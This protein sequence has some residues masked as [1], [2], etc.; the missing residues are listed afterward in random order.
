MKIECWNIRGFNKPLK[1]KCV[2]SLIKKQNLDMLCLLETKMD[3]VALN[4]ALGLR[5]SGMSCLSNSDFHNKIRIMLL[6]NACVASVVLIDMT[7]QLL[8]VKIDCL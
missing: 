2:Q 6:W 8:H 4:K 7:D 1:Q 5:F 3:T